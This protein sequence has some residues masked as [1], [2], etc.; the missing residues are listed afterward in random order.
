MV[1]GILCAAALLCGCAS[2]KASAP[3][4]AANN[5][6]AKTDVTPDLRPAGQV[7]MVNAEARFVVVNYPPGG[8][9]KP[10]RRLNVYRGGMKVGEVKVTG[11]ERDNNTVADILAGEVQ[12]HDQTREE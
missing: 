1:T 12:I 11:P 6:P 4:P 8:V 5:A 9:P 7:E 3:K 2:H 10:G